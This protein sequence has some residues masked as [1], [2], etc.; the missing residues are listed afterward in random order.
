[1]NKKE[2]IIR[3]EIIN[4]N[5]KGLRRIII[6]INKYNTING[7]IKFQILGDAIINRIYNMLITNQLL[8]L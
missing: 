2:N 5:F 3:E 4:L 7:I 8:L 1:M 6:D